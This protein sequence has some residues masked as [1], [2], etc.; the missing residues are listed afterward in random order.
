MKTLRAALLLSLLTLVRSHLEAQK[1]FVPGYVIRTTGD[2]IQGTI[3]DQNWDI[4]PTHITF[5][6]N[7]GKI[8]SLS[9]R[10]I[11]EFCIKGRVMEIYRT[12]IL[13]LDK[14]PYE[15]KDLQ[16]YP[17]PLISRDTVFATLYE[18]GTVA[19][20]FLRDETSRYHFLIEKN[21]TG[22]L[23]LGIQRFLRS[24]KMVS[25]DL[26]KNQLNRLMSDCPG[27]ITKLSDLEFNEKDLRGIVNYYNGCVKPARPAEAKPIYSQKKEKAGVTF[28]LMAG[29]GFRKDKLRQ[30]LGYHPLAGLSLGPSPNVDAGLWL[31]IILPRTKRALEICTEIE[32]NY[33]D[34]R[35]KFVYTGSSDVNTVEIAAHIVRADALLR[36]SLPVKKVTPTLSLGGSLGSAVAYTNTLNATQEAIPFVQFQWAFIAGAG[37]SIKN[38]GLE[39]RY[40]LGSSISHRFI[41]VSTPHSLNLTFRYGFPLVR[42]KPVR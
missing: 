14:G 34:Q 33:F 40:F 13:D 25:N 39:L 1:D 27:V 2:T 35:K 7:D 16:S 5:K 31:S 4:N 38:A 6:G 36:Y 23:D 24:T 15:L 29:V 10:D 12:R 42:E 37:I 3:D 22:I 30:S 21:D 28:G 11:R 19:L 17:T 41:V 18:T 20:Y 9:R 26:Y 8:E 32:W